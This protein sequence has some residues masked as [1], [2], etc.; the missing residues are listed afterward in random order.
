M[1]TTGIVLRAAQLDDIDEIVGAHL[2]AFP[3]F[4]L[5][6]LGFG[7][8]RELYR[9]F[10]SDPDGICLVAGRCTDGGKL[11]IVGF[12]AGAT[13][14]EPL[15]RRALISRGFVFALCASAAMLR[16]PIMVGR[17]LFSA[18]WYRGEKPPSIPSAT[19]LSSVAVVPDAQHGGIGRALMSEFCDAARARGS[20]WV[21]LTTDHHGNEAV[22][23]F[24]GSL[25]FTVF[26]TTTRQDGRTMST[27]V[28][29]L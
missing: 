8:L 25:G 21:Y 20:R 7:F 5:S 28:R 16:N 6:R 23:S 26:A 9:V 14:P 18:L 17:R 2:I 15:F 12:V 24:Y 27:Y 4:F 11:R 1:D 3:G 10:V 19:L 22:N 29:S 13:A